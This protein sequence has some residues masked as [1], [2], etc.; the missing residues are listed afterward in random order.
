MRTHDL[1]RLG[2]LPLYP[3]DI[4]P[5]RID[6]MGDYQTARYPDMSEVISCE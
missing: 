5:D 6:L 3:D 4:M 1:E 2:D